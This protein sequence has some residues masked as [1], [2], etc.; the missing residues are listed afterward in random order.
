[1]KKLLLMFMLICLLAACS[2]KENT[3]DA[4]TVYKIGI[5]NYVDDA[6]LNQI[7][8]NIEKG[9]HDI[10]AENN[11]EFDIR[12]DNANADS[13]VMNQIITNFIYD[14]VDLMIGIATPVAITMQTLTEENQ[15]P[16]VFAAVSDPEG[17]SLVDSNTNPGH[18]IT[19]TSDYL[20]TNAI[21]NLMKVFMPELKKVGLLYDL[22]QD[23]STGAINVAKK[24]LNDI[25]IE[26][27]EK[28]GTNVEE[29]R[30]ACQSLINE[31]VETIFTPS[32]NTVMTAELS[33]YEDMM[34][35]RILHYA[36]ADSF[37]LNGAFLGY[38]VDYAN[39]GYETALMVKEILIDGK[40]VS[41]LAVKTFD[42]G[43]VTINTDV[44]EKLGY[45]FD[46]L[47]EMFKPYCTSVQAIKTAES[48]E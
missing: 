29:I 45:S 1:M 30:L 8:E 18:N 19:G 24:I 35:A 40:D 6:S 39:L 43:I 10:E 21:I 11:V 31:N 27:V 4:K 37:A 9:L 14:E 28:T 33:I 26:V 47:A 20:D 36:G 42:N 23:S 22:G 32:D 41:T 3:T 48:F 44:C 34:N 15:I 12:Y 2:T 13:N 17:V 5:C 25:G 16:V 46:E 7:V 38:G